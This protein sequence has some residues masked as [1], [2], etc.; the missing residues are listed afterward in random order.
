MKKIMCLIC[1]MIG[2]LL[3]ASCSSQASDT[4]IENY[5]YGVILSNQQLNGK[6]QLYDEEGKFLG[7]KKL[8]ASGIDENGAS[9][10]TG[11]YYV[12]GK[13]YIGACSDLKAQ[14][15]ILEIDSETLEVKKIP[16]NIGEMYSYTG[17]LIQKNRLY[18]FY[19]APGESPIIKSSL[20]D[21]KKIK[22]IVI[23]DDSVLL[24]LIP[25]GEKLVLISDKA[26]K[27]GMKIRIL[28]DD[29]FNIEK[30]Y[31]IEDYSVSYDAVLKGDKL[32]MIPNSDENDSSTDKVIVND[33]L[34]GSKELLELPFNDPRYLKEV[35]NKLYIVEQDLESD[36][37]SIAIMGMDDHQIEDVVTFKHTIR[38]VVIDK[39]TMVLSSDDKVYVYNINNFELI[40]SFDIKTDDHL[41]FGSLLVKP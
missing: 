23:E 25:Y 19:S 38:D 26:G 14:D 1:T 30:E 6:L 24:H 8:K 18:T 34:N 27:Q 2:L 9:A 28:D 17:F 7:S 29:T 15:F 16:S 21:H 39:D 11:P 13:W 35:D 3:T 4:S 5:K 41:M 37:H 10:L 20:S 33:L 22:Q 31:R 32:Y 40:K 36:H 12:N